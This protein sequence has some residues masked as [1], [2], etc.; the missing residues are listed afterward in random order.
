MGIKMGLREGVGDT[1]VGL[2]GGKGEGKG[3]F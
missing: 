3:Y 2:W 1:G